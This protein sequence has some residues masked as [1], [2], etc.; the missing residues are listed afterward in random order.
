MTQF[1]IYYPSP[2]GLLSITVNDD[3]IFRIDFDN[4][5]IKYRVSSDHAI[6]A[7][8]FREFNNYFTGRSYLFNLPL[9]LHG[10]EFQVRVW[11]ELMKIPY[12]ETR[13]YGEIA[14][15]IGK[16]GGARAVGMACQ[17]NPLPVIIPCHRVIGKDGS[18]TGYAGQLWRKKW[19]LN[20]EEKNRK[21]EIIG[22]RIA[23]TE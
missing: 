1:N 9:I 2:L 7:L 17:Q 3:K 16:P 10:T 8:I 21:D 20:H 13:S 4:A 12:G 23:V 19:L 18:L 22:Q 15:A 14:G 11:K 5:D 6:F